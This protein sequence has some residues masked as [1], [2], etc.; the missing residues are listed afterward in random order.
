M[1]LVDRIRNCTLC[2]ELSTHRTNVVVGEGP[3][4]CAIVFLGE[5]PGKDED[6]SGRPFV[7][8]SGQRLESTAQSVGLQRGVDYHILNILKCRPL[9]NRDPAPEE[10]ENCRGFLE[11]QLKSIKPDV[12]V[13]FGR[14]AQ[15]FVLGVAPSKVKVSA[16]AGNVVD[17]AGAKAILTYHPAYINRV[18]VLEVEQA[19]TRHLRMARNLRNK[20]AMSKLRNKDQAGGAPGRVLSVWRPADRRR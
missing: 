16:Q 9:E 5:A 11:K 13:A 17:F 19:F 7:G 14:F 8:R 10:V 20:H 18:H 2:K 4:P 15:A 3:V 6:E 12:I 1:K